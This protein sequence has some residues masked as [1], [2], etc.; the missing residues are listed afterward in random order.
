MCI[1]HR[2]YLPSITCFLYAIWQLFLA[3]YYVVTTVILLLF[4][5]L[6]WPCMAAII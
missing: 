6:L 2:I 1:C 4:I 5:S 3:L